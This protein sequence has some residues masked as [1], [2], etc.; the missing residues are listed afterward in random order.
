VDG[1]NTSCVM[2]SIFGFLPQILTLF[3]GIKYFLWYRE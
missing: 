3:L 1:G 2:Q